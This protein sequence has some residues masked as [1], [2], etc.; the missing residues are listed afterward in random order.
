MKI[1]VISIIGYSGSGKTTLIEKLLPVLKGR[2]V[3]V[4]VIKHDSHHFEIDYEGKDT[5]RFTQAGADIVAIA[6]QEKSVV[7]VSRELD[8]DAMCAAFTD[9]DI[10]LTEGYKAGDK[11]KIEVHRAATG[12]PMYEKPENLLAIVTDVNLETDTPCF[13]MD[14]VEELVE[15]LLEWV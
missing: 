15:F 11:P 5:W 2:G 10:I 9:V 4:G 12:K 8:L 6:S 7:M 14:D 13:S 3:R 1:P